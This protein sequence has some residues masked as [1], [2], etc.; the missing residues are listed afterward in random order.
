[1]KENRISSWFGENKRKI[2]LIETILM[3]FI[4]FLMSSRVIDGYKR[5]GYKVYNDGMV[6]CFLFVPGFDG[7]DWE[8]RIEIAKMVDY[9]VRYGVHLIEYLILGNLFLATLNYFIKYDE[10]KRRLKLYLLIFFTIV[11]LAGADEIHQS[12]VLGQR[13]E[14]YDVFVEAVAAL[15]GAY[16]SE[17]YINK[18]KTKK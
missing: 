2:Y 12:F 16:L 17:F 9:P 1:M 4:I 11:T 7:F 15:I 5:A 3:L 6:A 8:D 10:E 13:C 14:A 18:N